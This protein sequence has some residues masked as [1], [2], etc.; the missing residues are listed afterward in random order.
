MKLF[1]RRTLVAGALA[2]L[3]LNSLP[4]MAQGWPSAK[5]IRVIVP[6]ASGGT[7]DV[8]ARL[9]GQRLGPALNTQVV[10]ENKAGANGIVG[11]EALAKS[12]PDGYSL[13]IVAPGHASNVSLYKKLPYDT[14]ADFEPVML[15]LTQPSMLVVHASVP[16]NS[17]AELLA[18]AKS[19][20]GVMNYASGGNGSSQHLAAAM[21]ASMAGLDMVH[22][23]YKGSGPAEAALLGGQVNMMFASMVTALPQVKQGRLRALAVS[24]EKR[25]TA[26]PDL[27]TVAESGVSG[28]SAVAWA[29]L[30]A[31]KGTPA[32]IVARLNA[33]IA[34]IMASPDMKERLSGLGAEFV[35]NSPKDFDGFIRSEITRWADVVKRA[36]IRV[37]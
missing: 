26:T 33:E 34:K 10:V 23:P 25:S 35:P 30:L 32:P 2:A 27:P 17:V 9:I 14:L 20:P 36:N 31:P 22:V 13:V 21:F 29:G 11:S 16:V 15:L 1:D 5:P 4:A 3:A 37:D 24:S 6:F 12:A 18:L 8:V 28:Y 19:K 7:T